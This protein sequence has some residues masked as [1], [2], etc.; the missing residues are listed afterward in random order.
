MQIYRDEL[1]NLD[2]SL[3]NIVAAPATRARSTADTLALAV[4]S[5][6]NL[7]RRLELLGHKLPS[8]MDCWDE[9]NR[10]AERIDRLASTIRGE[11][12]DVH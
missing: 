5:V 12:H 9:I 7:R 6:I 4:D 11:V 10:M 1:N 3:N 8:T 2:R